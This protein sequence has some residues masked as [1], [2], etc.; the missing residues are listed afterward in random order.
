MLDTRVRKFLADGM[1]LVNRSFSLAN[2]RRALFLNE[3]ARERSSGRNSEIP[4]LRFRYRDLRERRVIMTK[5]R[6]RRKK[7]KERNFCVDVTRVHRARYVKGAFQC[8]SFFRDC[9]DRAGL[10]AGNVGFA[11]QTPKNP[12]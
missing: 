4:F 7:R 5:L 10:N 9:D 11:R 2:N 1:R 12:A 6:Q 3:H 8:R